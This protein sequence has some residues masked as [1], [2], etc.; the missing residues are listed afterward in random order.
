MKRLAEL[1]K[2]ERWVLAAIALATAVAVLFPLL[3]SYGLWDPQEITVADQA[4]QLTRAGGYLALWHKQL[5][6]T[7]WAVATGTALFGASELGARLPL[8][9]LG[10]IAALASYGVGARPAGPRP[11]AVAGERRDQAEQR[12]RQPRPELA[13]AEERRAGRDRPRRERELLVPQR[14]V[15]AGAGEL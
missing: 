2:D 14:Q 6:F 1:R 7:P 9:L 13:G 12:E 15:A 11:D 3:G 5:P 4:R 10:L 8:A